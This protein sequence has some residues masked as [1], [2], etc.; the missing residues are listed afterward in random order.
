MAGRAA[1]KAAGF[2]FTDLKAIGRAAQSA[3]GFNFQAAGIAT[4]KAAGTLGIAGRAAQK[5]SGCNL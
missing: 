3:S 5:D 1:Q 2:S 4:Q